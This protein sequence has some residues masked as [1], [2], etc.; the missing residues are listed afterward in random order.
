MVSGS[1]NAD[2][3]RKASAQ[4]LAVTS[5]GL[6]LAQRELDVMRRLHHPCLLPLLQNELER[7]LTW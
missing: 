2:L 7:I 5:E 1:S 4:V 3:P 6:A